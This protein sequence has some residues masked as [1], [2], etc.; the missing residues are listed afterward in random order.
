M[1]GG[2]ADI[3]AAGE[4]AS[5]GGD[6]AGIGFAADGFE[7]DAGFSFEDTAGHGDDLTGR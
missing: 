4:E 6:M 2:A 7:A 1:E 3:E 5:A